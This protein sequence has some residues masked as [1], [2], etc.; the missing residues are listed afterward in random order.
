MKPY[1]VR[2]FSSVKGKASKAKSDKKYRSTAKGNAA[3]AAQRKRYKASANGKAAEARY[4]SSD[5][6]ELARNARQAKYSTTLKGR[7]ALAR[8]EASPKRKISLE[9][10][11]KSDKGRTSR[12]VYEFS[13]TGRASVNNA[14]AKRRALKINAPIRDFTSAQWKALQEHFSHRCAY[15]G[16]RAKGHLTQDHITPLSK[17]G[18]HTLSNIVPACKSCNSKKHTGEP[19]TPVQPMLLAEVG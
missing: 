12:K 19:L 15:C 18:N 10:Y 13:M 2:W 7:A 6:G 11:R 3:R 8:Y 4:Q 16:R 5:K 17:G 9:K 14:S 1:Q